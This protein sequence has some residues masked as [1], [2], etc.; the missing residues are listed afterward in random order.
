V[1][2]EESDGPLCGTLAEVNVVEYEEV[3][4]TRLEVPRILDVLDE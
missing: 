1:E 3:V 2:V 4:D